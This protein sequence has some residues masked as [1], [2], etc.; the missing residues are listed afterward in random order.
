VVSG[1]VWKVEPGGWS[2]HQA[3]KV[4]NTPT[5]MDDWSFDFNLIQ[6]IS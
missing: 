3:K 1:T 2:Y 6:H 4:C 5:E